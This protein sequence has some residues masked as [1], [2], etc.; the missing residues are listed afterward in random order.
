MFRTLKADKDTYITNKYIDGKPAV[1]G[2]VGIAGSLDLFKL[3]GITIV[4]SGSD[5]IPQYELTRALIHFDLNP[6]QELYDEGRVDLN[7]SSF[8]CFLNLKDVYG[9][10]PT[11]NNFIIDI[12][13]MSASW[14]EGLGKDVAYYSDEDKCN[15]LSASSDALWSAKGCEKACFATGSGDYITSSLSIPNTKVSQTF[16]KG[17]ED[18]L[19][20][21]TSIISATIKGELPDQ[22]FR[23]SY[24][25][26]IE[27]NTKTYFVKRFASRHAYDESKHPKLLIKF[28]DSI[29]DDSSNLYLDTPTSASIF[30]YNYVHGQ[31]TNLLSASLA[32]TGS[33]SILLELQSEISGTGKYSL[34][35]TGSQ[36]KFG[37]NFST[38]IY[39]ASV[40]LPL[41]NVNIKASFDLSGSVSFT[42]IWTSVDRTVVYTTG[43]NVIA[44][45]PE[46]ISYRLNPRRYRVNVAGI[47]TDYTEEEEV[48]MRVYIFDENDPQIFAKRV[49]IQIP[50]LSL[51][52]VHYAIRNASTNEYA[53]PFDTT[54][55]STKISSDSN[56]MYFNFNTS[57]LTSQNVYVVDI[58]LIVDNLQQKYL[59]A[60]SEFRIITM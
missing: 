17:D 45:A 46:R 28:N 14:T 22:G 6:L 50:G 24:S 29:L 15:F 2:N 47:S 42:P 36:H 4:T 38:G 33:N 58:M 60:S 41:S 7:H 57:A 34:F 54:Y 25:S 31:L 19:V 30:L 32:V 5:K 37:T 48:T 26:T 49:P 3:Y 53:I 8:K 43:S 40:N 55:N 59:N 20:D 10:Q 51:R 44:K 1:S 16:A 39:S 18:L 23:L 27:E 11:P 13:P 35:F 52:N 9:G 12:F 21:I 56:G